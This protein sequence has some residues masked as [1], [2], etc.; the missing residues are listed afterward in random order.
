VFI[1]GGTKTEREVYCFDSESGALLW[2]KGVS[3]STKKAPSV[4]QETGYAPSTMA[5]DG[6]RVFAIFPNG[7]LICFDLEGKQQWRK[8]FGMPNNVY[9]HASSLTV[10]GNGLIVQLDQGM[11]PDERKSHLYAL[12][13][14]TGKPVWSVAREV[15]GSWST[16]I[17]VKVDGKDQLI[18]VSNPLVISYDPTNGKEIWRSE[19]L[20]GDVSPSATFG[21]GYVLV[22]NNGAGLLALKPNLTGNITKTGQSW[23]V[24]DDV[25]DIV[26]LLSAND[27]VYMLTTSGMMTCVD[28][29][30]GKK[31]WSHDFGS[32]FN[33]SPV[34]AASKVF[35]TEISG[36]THI[37][38]GGTSFKELSTASVGE[39]VRATLAIVNGKLYIRG[40]E[41][42][43]C[44]GDK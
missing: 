26:S 39:D 1:S 31:V 4:N 32:S 44:I 12:D 22:A 28:A 21:G 3:S 30:N 42:L 14:A 36:K 17:V 25:P 35:V 18:T 9:G 38:D 41:H 11:A 37:L 23:K 16:P 10:Y 19:C 20:S 13:G 40:N 34:F 43:F 33:S 6:K 29:K 24:E 8:D 2:K 7:D 5:S 15:G 27:L